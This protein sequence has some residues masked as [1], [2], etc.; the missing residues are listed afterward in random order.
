MEVDAHAPS[1][2]PIRGRFRSRRQRRER[3]FG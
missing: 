1:G 2:M 3:Y